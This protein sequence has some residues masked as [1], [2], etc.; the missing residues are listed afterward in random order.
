MKTALD[1][2]RQK[3]IMAKMKAELL[4]NPPKTILTPQ[5]QIYSYEDIV[6]MANYIIKKSDMRPK[7]GL[8]LGPTSYD[9]IDLIEN[10]TIIEYIDI[11]KFPLCKCMGEVGTLFL[12]TI[13]GAPAMAFLG[14]CHN[15]EGNPLGTCGMPVQVMKLCGVEY[16]FLSCSS[17]AVHMDYNE[18]DILLIKDHINLLGMFGSSPLQGPNEKRFGIRHPR[19]IDAYDQKMLKKAVDIGHEIGYEKNI[20]LGVYACLGGPIYETEAEQLLLRKIGANAVGM[21]LVHEVSPS[22]TTR[23]DRTH[24]P[25]SC[26]GRRRSSLRHEDI[27]LQSNCNDGNRPPK[28]SSKRPGSRKTGLQRLSLPH[29]LLHR[30]RHARDPFESGHT[31]QR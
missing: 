28:D 31:H 8:I 12:G 2:R 15:Y 7:Y 6:Q 14:R 10:R 30:E 11:P 18:G 24:E 27:R 19:M 3:L 13:M 29:D 22:V 1:L 26:L 4:A 23:N 21:T 16:L 17:G 20:H 9:I 25:T 5:S